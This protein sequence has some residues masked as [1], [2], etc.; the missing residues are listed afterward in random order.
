MRTTQVDPDLLDFT[1]SN[2]FCLELFGG[3]ERQLALPSASTSCRVSFSS[4]PAPS[5]TSPAHGW[6][7]HLLPASLSLIT[8]AWPLFT[9]CHSP[10]FCLSCASCPAGCCIA[11]LTSG[12]LL[13]HLSSLCH[14][15]SAFASAFFSRASSPAGCCLAS[16]L[17]VVLTVAAN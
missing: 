17:L 15:P 2:K 8:V 11:S 1:R 7:L 10:Q 5:I 13:H 6:L 3:L 12:W 14:L 9:F 16:T 4:A